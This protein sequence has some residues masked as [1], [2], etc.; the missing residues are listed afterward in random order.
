MKKMIMLVA[1]FAATMGAIAAEIAPPLWA[2]ADGRQWPYYLNPDG[3]VEI[4]GVYDYS[5]GMFVC[6]INPAPEGVV[7]V[8]GTL[9]GRPVTAIGDSGY[10]SSEDKKGARKVLT[11]AAMTYVAAMAM[12]LVYLLRYIALA[13]RRR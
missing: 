12:S 7:N 3:S 9:D 10:F 5:R 11:A 2:T 4:C 1:A 13:R 8:P 6:G